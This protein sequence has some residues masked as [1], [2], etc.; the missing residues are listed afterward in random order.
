[1][2]K[3]EPYMPG[4]DERP[5]L[6]HVLTQDFVAVP[7]PR[8]VQLLDQMARLLHPEVKWQ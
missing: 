7:G 5:G 6:F 4:I 2:R 3:V 8:F 1:M